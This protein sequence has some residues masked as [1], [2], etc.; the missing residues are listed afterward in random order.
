MSHLSWE[1]KGVL[2]SKRQSGRPQSVSLYPVSTHYLCTS[3]C[4]RPWWRSNTATAAVATGK[5]GNENE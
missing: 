1:G 5:L 4:N 2:A 3:T